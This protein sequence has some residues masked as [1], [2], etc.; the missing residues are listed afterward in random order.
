MDSQR[1]DALVFFGATGDLAYKKI[2]PALQAMVKRGELTEPIVGVAK[3]GWGL[4]QLKERARASCQEH[5]DGGVDEAAFAKL[6]SLLRYVDGDYQDP[7]TF[8]QLRDTLGDARRPTHYLAIPPV[9]FETVIENLSAEGCSRG[10]R[11]VVEKPFGHNLESARELNRI[12]SKCFDESSVFRIDHYLGK[13][14]VQNL[15]YF[16]FANSFLE[17]VWNREHI[18]HV[19]INMAE[20]FGV[21]GRGVFYDATG[22]VRDVIQNHAL[23]ILSYVAMEPPCGPDVE[24]IR[25]EKANVLRAIPPVDPKDV[26][27]GQF[28]GFRDEKGVAADSRTET[29]AALRLTV[30]SPRWRGVPFLIRAGKHLPI[31]RAEV[32]VKL[33]PSPCVGPGPEPPPNYFRF[34]IGPSA[35]IAFGVTVMGQM[36]ESPGVPVELLASHRRRAD[37]MRSYERL[38]GEAMSGDQALFAREDYV[39]EEWRIIDPILKSPPRVQEYEPNTWGPDEADR[40]A[41]EFGG[42]DNPSESP[43]PDAQTA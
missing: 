20:A 34:Q 10:A 37:E 40:I 41:A 8:R 4:D 1:S 2:F 24:A 36:L 25:D 18:E 14:P 3:S 17:P 9:L 6:S 33:R 21:E 39:E 43:Q 31:T 11:V 5:A 15:R 35:A 13:R 29:F 42:W 26:V 22:A 23:Q 38:L 16:R 19:Q 12:L 32:L 7:A 28:R 30:E 27:L